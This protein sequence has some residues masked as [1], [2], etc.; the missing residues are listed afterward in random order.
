MRKITENMLHAIRH[1]KA[2]HDSNTRTERTFPH[3]NE[4]GLRVYLHNNQIAFI[5]DDEDAPIKITLAGWDT[6]TTRNRVNAI[7]YAFAGC[8]VGRVKGFTTITFPR[9][10]DSNRAPGFK[11]T[12]DEW[13]TLNR[14]HIRERTQ[15][16]T[17]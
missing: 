13:V 15:Q 16:A 3:D 11:V 7:A 14:R 2:W 9:H 1:A 4:Q 12:D 5:P 8:W 17:A 6:P 10:D